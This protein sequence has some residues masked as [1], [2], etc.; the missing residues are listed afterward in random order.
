MRKFLLLGGISSVCLL[1][2]EAFVSPS[3][4]A[5]HQQGI[6]S[7]S[8]A[9]YSVASA[10][11]VKRRRRRRDTGGSDGDVAG[12]TTSGDLPDFELDEDEEE[13]DAKSK[14]RMG[15]L[16]PDEITPSMMGS[17]SGP[18]RSVDDLIADR[19]LEAKLDFDDIEQDDSLPDLIELSRRSGEDG[20]LTGTKKARQA[21]RRA[22][23]IAAKEKEEDNLFSN[24]P[25]VTDTEGKVQP[26]KVS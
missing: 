13:S 11:H 21:E 23:A 8:N 14:K 9:G 3:Y 19:S 20:V 4:A 5:R 12:D 25:F 26:I 10:L 2:G 15:I 7:N 17:A 1:F 24:L 22:A 6:N 16:K 18:V